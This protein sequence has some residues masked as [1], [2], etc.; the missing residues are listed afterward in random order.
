MEAFGKLQLL[1]GQDIGTITGSG[2][3]MHRDNLVCSP[4]I[5][6]TGA[7]DASERAKS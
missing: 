7:K 6:Y 4:C 1:V 3:T 2:A 5:T